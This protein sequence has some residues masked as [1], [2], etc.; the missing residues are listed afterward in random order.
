MNALH[1]GLVNTNLLQNTV[2]GAST[3]AGAISVEEGIRSIIFL[4]T[5]AD[6]EGLSGQYYFYC[7]VRSITLSRK[8]GELCMYNC[9]FYEQ[10]VVGSEQPEWAKSKSEADKLWSASLKFCGIAEEEYGRS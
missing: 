8:Y 1:P 2:L 6:V 10:V 4:A 7:K 3:I 5:A 9:I